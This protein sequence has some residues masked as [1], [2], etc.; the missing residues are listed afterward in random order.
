MTEVKEQLLTEHK[1][2]VLLIDDQPM[3]GE[4]VRRML[5]GEEDIDFHFVSDPTKAIPTAEE[6]QPT[7]ILQDL[8]MPE[9]DGMTMVKFMRVN[10][11]LKDIPLIV[12]STKE[13][14]TTKAEAFALGANDYLVKLPDR[15]ELLARIRYH[16]KGYINLL[17]RNEAYEQLRESR[18]EMRKELAVAADY[19]TSLLPDPVKEGNIQADWRFIPSASLGGDSFGYHWLDDDHFAMY[20]LDVCDHGVGS[21]LLSV[22]AMNVL[23]SQTLPDTDFLKPDEVLTSLNDSFQM[24]Q[25][26]NLY[27]TM[28]YGI[29]RKSDRTLTFSS[30]GH[31]PALLIADGEVQQ[32]RTPGMIVGGM[33]DMTYTSDSV[34]VE[35]G[36]R[37]FL[38]SDGVYELKKVSDGK[39]WEFDEF[40]GFMKGTGGELGTP[41]DQLIAH[42]RQLQ[43]S[44]LYEDDFSMVEFV[45]A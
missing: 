12:L 18:D 22:S 42:T 30:G 15:I 44:E 14:P 39:M 24:D 35:P 28:W 8:V 33:P 29:Y 21:A 11:K 27:F 17:Q 5:E 2:N 40:S 31:P 37:F 13:E 9:I 34:T 3:V 25:Q 1:I 20:L 16:S 10:S 36:A 6:L 23:R 32:L 26:N 43:G 19:V 4:A 7:V 38:Y 45:F 41:I